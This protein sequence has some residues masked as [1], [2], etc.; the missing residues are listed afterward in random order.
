[1]NQ[2][3]HF[4]SVNVFLL[5]AYHQVVVVF[6]AAAVDFLGGVFIHIKHG[7]EVTEKS[8]FG[9]DKFLTCRGIKEMK[10]VTMTSLFQMLPLFFFFFFF[11]KSILT[12]RVF[13]IEWWQ[14]EVSGD[15]WRLTMCSLCIRG[16]KLLV[17][18]LDS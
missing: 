6:L 16:S 10:I 1:M 18:L 13:R 4:L 3:F 9:N 12:E 14:L 7:A 8:R 2:D 15:T 17:F 5:C 11:N